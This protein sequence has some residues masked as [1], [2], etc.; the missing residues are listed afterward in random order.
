M[1]HSL[2]E[3]FEGIISGITSFGIFVELENTVEGI[4]RLS[5][6]YDDYYFFDEDRYMLFGEMTGK[7]YRIGDIV[8]VRVTKTDKI[9][10]QVEFYLIGPVEEEKP[11]KE[12]KDR[13]S[14]NKRKNQISGKN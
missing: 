1:E 4:V 3:T 11:E 5:D 10:R 2:G 7:E 13:K 12:D 14:Q 9:A 8:K 6:M